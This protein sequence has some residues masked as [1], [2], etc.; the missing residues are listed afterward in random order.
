MALP[1]LTKSWQFNVNNLLTSQGSAS[2]TC[3][4]LMYNIVSAMTGFA[5]SPWVVD[6]SCLTTGNVGTKGDGI[7]RWTSGSAL[8]WFTG[9]GQNLVAHSWIVLKQTGINSNYEILIDLQTSASS[10]TC[11]QIL[12][13][14]SAGFTG[15]T[16]IVPP[17]ASD[18][19]VLIP[20]GSSTTNVSINLASDLQVRWSVMQSTD[21]TCTRMFAF[22]GGAMISGF[23]L[24]LPSNIMSGWTTPSYSYWA[25][26]ASLTFLSNTIGAQ[27]ALVNQNTITGTAALTCEGNMNGNTTSPLINQL[28]PNDLDNNWPMLPI[29]IWSS[30]T[31]MRGR[32]GTMND[33]WAGSNSVS[34]GTTYPAS[35]AQFIQVGNLIFPWNG[36]A[37]NIS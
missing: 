27:N 29:G 16:A 10:K 26:M 7:N 6:Y 18:S 2:A 33:I 35:G 24:D 3:N 5:N 15:G 25:G 31:G 1:T 17:T 30:T 36:G 21:G 22:A 32:L 37:V 4:Q 12:I 20:F 34:L 28:V 11:C 19:R 8:V 23:I 13:S 9:G 14:P